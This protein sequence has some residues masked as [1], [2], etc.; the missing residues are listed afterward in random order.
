MN[1]QE[2]ADNKFWNEAEHGLDPHSGPSYANCSDG[3]E[4]RIQQ[5]P[6]AQPRSTRFIWGDITEGAEEAP[7]LSIQHPPAHQ[8]HFSCCPPLTCSQH[9]AGTHV[10][11]GRQM[12]S[13]N[14]IRHSLHAGENK[15]TARHLEDEKQFGVERYS[16]LY[17]G[18]SP[19][20]EVRRRKIYL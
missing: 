20:L 18:Y 9:S 13:T 7:K 8:L 2:N 11:V 16:L 12:E 17:F 19:S 4:P 5:L 10:P 3:T 6:A 15:N 14:L 1:E